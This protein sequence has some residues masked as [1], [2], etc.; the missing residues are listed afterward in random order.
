MT[1]RG[2]CKDLH[3]MGKLQEE[4]KWV[5]HELTERQMENWRATSKI[6]LMR[7][8]RKSFLHRIITG[9]EKWIYFE[10]TK[11]KKSWYHLA[12]H[13]HQRRDQI[14]SERK[15]CSERTRKE[16]Y[17]MSCWNW[18]KLSMSIATDNNWSILTMHC[19]KNG[20]NGARDT[21]ERYCS[22]TK[23]RAIAFPRQWHHSNAEMERSAAPAV[24]ARP[25]LLRLSLALVDSAWLGRT[26][27]AQFRRSAKLDEWFRS[28]N[29]SFFRGGIHVLPE[30]AK[31]CS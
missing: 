29:T 26:T 24:F 27:L 21:N 3:A 10:N 5:P 7:H 30:M 14:A 12:K 11:C 28:E 1:R 19:S 25:G 18:A 31:M 23:L 2:I 16:S 20:Q 6:L 8:E 15:Q 4:G 17:T 9:G 13:R 22:T